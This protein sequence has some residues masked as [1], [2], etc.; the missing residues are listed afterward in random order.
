MKGCEKVQLDSYSLMIV[1]KYFEGK[2]DFKN[3]VQVCKKFEHTC[4]LFHYNPIKDVSLFPNIDTYYKYNSNVVPANGFKL[5]SIRYTISYEDYMNFCNDKKKTYSYTRIEYTTRNR[6]KYG[7]EIP[8]VVTTLADGCFYECKLEQIIIPDNVVEIIDKCFYNCCNLRFVSMSK[9]VKH[10]GS[11]CFAESLL[12]SKIEVRKCRS[13][14]TLVSYSVAKLIEASGTTCTNVIL[15]S[16]L[17]SMDDIEEGVTIIGDGVLNECHKLPNLVLPSTVQIIKPKALSSNTFVTS[18]TIKDKK[19]FNYEVP[20]NISEL[21]FRGGVRCTNITFTKY[22]RKKF[23]VNIPMTAN[24]LGHKCFYNCYGLQFVEI[25]NTIH[26]ISDECFSECS[27]LRTLLMPNSVKYIDSK[28]FNNCSSLRKLKLSPTVRVLGNRCFNNASALTSLVVPSS[29]QRLGKGCFYSCLSL[30]KV[31]VQ[32]NLTKIPDECFL[33]CVKLKELTLPDTITSFGKRSF[34]DCKSIQDLRFPT[35]LTSVG[36]ECFNNCTSLTIVDLPNRVHHIGCNCFSNCSSLIEIT[37]NSPVKRLESGTFRNCI[38]LISVRLN[39]NVETLC[40]KC[41]DGCSSLTAISLP[42]NLKL[43]EN[44]CFDG[45]NMLR[46]I[47]NYNDQIQVSKETIPKK[48]K[49]DYENDRGSD[50]TQSC[51]IN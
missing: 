46:S 38:D 3:V 12:L 41:F 15:D 17:G 19:V 7:D 27:S 25:P 18:L 40:V 26:S 50:I 23:D 16:K 11:D 4:E 20:F 14:D 48:V 2:A 30:R 47:S 22:D 21:L 35:S 24:T 6:C 31:V 29:V 44:T 1:S 39:H 42:D 32:A 37:I 8:S 5:Y 43:I 49:I 9:N 51:I 33:K 28:V 36:D 13:F 10:I 34:E 45:C